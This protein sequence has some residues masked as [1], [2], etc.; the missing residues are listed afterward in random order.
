MG[1]D[2][3]HDCWHGAYSSFTRW[4]NELASVAGYQLA[5]IEYDDGWRS[6]TVLID[7]GHLATEE[8]LAGKWSETPGDPLLVL[9]VHSD[10]DGGIYPEQAQVLADRLEELLPLLPSKNDAG[11]I[12]NWRNK[13]QQFIDGLREA[14]DNYEV[15]EF[16]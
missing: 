8:T 7:W 9:I 6:E 4:R 10:C 3:T 14:F 2:T 15:V 13:T 1:L 12:G 5:T 11:H 16:H